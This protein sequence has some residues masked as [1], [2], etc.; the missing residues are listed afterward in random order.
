MQSTGLRLS[1]SRG[2]RG[3]FP[4]GSFWTTWQLVLLIA[5]VQMQCFNFG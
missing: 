3:Y 5:V 1:Q 2:N 4:L